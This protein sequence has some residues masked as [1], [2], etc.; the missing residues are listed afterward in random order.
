[1]AR[2]A[3]DE[4]VTA[5]ARAVTDG[6]V[7]ANRL[8]RLACERH[9]DDLVSGAS[10]GLRFDLTAAQHAISFFGF[11]RHSKGEWAGETF[12]LAPWQAFVVGSLF[13]WQRS[14]GLRRFRTAY[15]AVPRKNGK[16]TLSAGIALYL[17]V[18]DGEQGAEI[19][20][21]A[22]TRD[23]AR[24]VFDEAKRMVSSS[25]A[26][27]HRVQVLINN[28]NIEGS[29]SRFMPLSS[30][31]SSMDGLNVHGAII[32]EL[33]AHKTRGVV[34]VLDTATGA[35]R[36][37]LLFEITTAGYDR[38][39]IC[40]EHQDYAI[41]LLEGTLQDDSWFAFIAS[42]DEGDDWTDP[43]VW[44]KANPSFG[45]SVKEDD[46]ARKAEKDVALRGAQ[47]AFRRMH[48]NEWTE[49]A[50]RWIDLAVWDACSGP[51]DLEQLRGKTC[52]GGLDLSAT[53]D[54]TA[55]AWV[56]PPE[57][58]GFWYLLSRYFVPEDN[59]R[60]RAER[61]RV[62]YDLWTL[63]GFIEATPGN[64][65]D[66]SAIEQR[67]LADAALFQVKEIAYDPWNATHIALRLQD[68]GAAMVEFR[69]GF[70]SMA[71]PTRE[72]EKL[73]VSQKLAHGGNPVTRWMAAN[74]AV[75]QD[76]AGNLK[77]AK[78]KSTDRIDGIVAL[79]MAIGRAMVA[80]DE[81][82]VSYQLFWV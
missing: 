30:D 16:S 14:D 71:A 1:V 74:V 18:A 17:L 13:G 70:R 11:L 20:S 12:V 55:L 68:E 32:D 78:D 31:A 35:R 51:V 21:A 53:T 67:I 60:K 81:P 65:V 79:I 27:R 57:D 44:R 25:P 82:Y 41:K 7:L 39:S 76:P 6:Q 5:Y 56:F 33:H 4:P 19:Y 29:A 15:C 62:P 75:A 36:Q 59:L 3:R 37:P 28:L 52:F 54:V 48:L 34:D 66:Y 61:D 58:D 50:E 9:L 45:L 47:N 23:Q 8:V 24:I 38:H 22:T 69:Q 43:E 80:Q 77:P 10:R 46:L 49:Q 72:L 42:A 26:L 40:F 73:I 64:V 2:A 63:Q